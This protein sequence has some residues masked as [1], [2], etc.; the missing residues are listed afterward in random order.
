MEV[1]LNLHQFETMMSMQKQILEQQKFIMNYMPVPECIDVKYICSKLDL[2]KSKIY[3]S[4]WL[5]PNFGLSDYATATK[6]WKW[7]SWEKWQEKDEVERRKEWLS[8]PNKTKEEI[9]DVTD[10]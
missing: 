8:L 3:S 1:T 9:M 10:E 5:I 7:D 4:P 6:R 2:S